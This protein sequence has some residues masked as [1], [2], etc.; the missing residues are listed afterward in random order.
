MNESLLLKCGFEVAKCDTKFYL[1]KLRKYSNGIKIISIEENFYSKEIEEYSFEYDGTI[2][3]TIKVFKAK[4]NFGKTEFLT[5]IDDEVTI[6]K[7]DELIQLT[8]AKNI[9]KLGFVYLIKSK[10][11][12]KIGYSKE[13]HNRNKIFN[14]KLP[15]Q[16]EFAKIFCL[17]DYKLFEKFLH[18]IFVDKKL[19]GEWF[20]LDEEDLVSIEKVYTQ[21]IPPK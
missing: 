5:F 19:N 16:W 12:Y 8:S 17:Q 21:I 3:K 1:E 20:D 4:I 2:S 18:N 9:E 14:V 10:L 7:A 13:I 11:G 15:F 6:K